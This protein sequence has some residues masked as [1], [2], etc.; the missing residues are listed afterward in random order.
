MGMKQLEIQFCGPDS[1][2]GTKH[3]PI[4]TPTMPNQKE[5]ISQQFRLR[6]NIYLTTFDRHGDRL[7]PDLR[8]TR[9]FICM[10]CIA[11]RI[12]T[13]LSKAR[14]LLFGVECGKSVGKNHQLCWGFWI[15]IQDYRQLSKNSRS[16][17]DSFF[18]SDR[19]WKE[20]GNELRRRCPGD[21]VNNHGLLA[22]FK[23]VNA[24]FSQMNRYGVNFGFYWSVW[25]ILGL[26]NELLVQEIKI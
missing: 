25:I 3:D 1:R 13:A 20:W 9:G 6:K 10:Y 17:S 15:H 19:C 4:L 22:N 12:L 5:F 18:S 26:D 24:I 16:D 14:R 11:L 8:S 2:C 23:T 21:Q 7:L